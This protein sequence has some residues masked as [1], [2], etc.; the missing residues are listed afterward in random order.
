MSRSILTF[1]YIRNYNKC[2]ARQYIATFA[3]SQCLQGI[4]NRI[5]YVDNIFVSGRTNELKV[6]KRLEDHVL[7]LDKGKCDFMKERIEVLG[8]VIDT[9]SLHKAKSKVKAMI[10]APRPTDSKQLASFLG[11]VNFY[12]NF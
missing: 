8:Y 1:I 5:E 9:N 6:C 3:S 7:R 4:P 10:E 12:Y 2:A 11:L